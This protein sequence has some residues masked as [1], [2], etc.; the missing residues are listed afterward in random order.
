[1]RQ[2]DFVTLV[3]QDSQQLITVLDSMNALRREW[4]SAGYLGNMPPEAFE[5]DNAGATE[6][7]IAAV[8]GTTLDALNALMASGHLTNLY[9]VL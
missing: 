5:G 3:R 1:M 9:S 7:E 4:D 6:D 8:I 2:A